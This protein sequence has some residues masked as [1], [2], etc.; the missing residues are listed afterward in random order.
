[1]YFSLSKPVPSAGMLRRAELLSYRVR[2]TGEDTVSDLL[3]A[4]SYLM[5]IL[6]GLLRGP[7]FETRARM[8]AWPE[9]ATGRFE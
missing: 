4:W 2:L 5:V 6:P 1:M 3:G 7:G 9:Y 8:P